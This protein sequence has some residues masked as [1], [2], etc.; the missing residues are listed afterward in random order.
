[1]EFVSLLFHQNPPIS[2]FVQ[3]TGE[4]DKE[5][6][7]GRVGFGCGGRGHGRRPMLPYSNDPNLSKVKCAV[8]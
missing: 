8:Y 1:M 3:S 4:G 6:Y 2:Q 7:G 5:G